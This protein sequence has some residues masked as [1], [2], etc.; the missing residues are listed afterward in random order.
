LAA[1]RTPTTR[2][3]YGIA[4]TGPETCYAVGNHGTMLVLR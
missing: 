1:Q 2:D 4:C 3:L